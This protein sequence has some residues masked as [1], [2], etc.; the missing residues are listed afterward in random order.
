VPCEEG[1]VWCGQRA[2]SVVLNIMV[3]IPTTSVYK[4]VDSERQ[5]ESV[6]I[7]FNRLLIRSSSRF[8]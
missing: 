1:N 2:E 3:H 5:G 4:S 6:Y 8:A 7:G